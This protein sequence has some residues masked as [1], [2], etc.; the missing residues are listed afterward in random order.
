MIPVHMRNFEK[1]FGQTEDEF[2]QWVIDTDPDV[3]KL[4]IDKYKQELKQ[5]Q[6]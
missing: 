2:R 1:R 6:S 3:I 5:D 4:E